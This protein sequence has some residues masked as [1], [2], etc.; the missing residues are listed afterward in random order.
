MRT[1]WLLLV[2]GCGGKD[3]GDTAPVA[4]TT[5]A[6]APAT[7]GGATGAGSTTDACTPNPTDPSRYVIVGFWNNDPTCSGDPMITNAFPVDPAAG[8]Y[9]WPGNSGEN[10]ADGFACDPGAGSFTYTQYNSLTC[11]LDD[12]SPTAKTAWTDRCEQDIPANLYAMIV[13]YGAC[14]L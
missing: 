11:G 7:T 8:C 9:C 1:G 13:D 10:S 14:A 3:A 4:T 5:G 12:D 2:L 6:G